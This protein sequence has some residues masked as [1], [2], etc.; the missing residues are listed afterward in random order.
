[1]AVSGG[2]Y[3]FTKKNIE[4]SPT[5]QGIYSLY[6]EDK[7]IYIGRAEGKKGIRGCLQRH[8]QGEE[9]DCTKEATHYRRHVCQNIDTMERVYIQE[10]TRLNGILPPCNNPAS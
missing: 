10:Y 7:V 9:G 6:K 3:A 1:M 2:K 8:K 4:K 5:S